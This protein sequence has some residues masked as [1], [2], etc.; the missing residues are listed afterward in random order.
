MRARVV[1]GT[2]YPDGRH[3]LHFL[4]LEKNEEGHERLRTEDVD[5]AEIPPVV[6]AALR[7]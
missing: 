7:I 5:K 2:F 3:V 6:Y 1:G 4:V